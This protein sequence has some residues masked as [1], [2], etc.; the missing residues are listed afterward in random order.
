VKLQ[1]EA[2]MKLEAKVEELKNLAEELRM[3]IMEKDTPLDHL[4]KQNEELISSSS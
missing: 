4:Q 2:R 3:D 1:D